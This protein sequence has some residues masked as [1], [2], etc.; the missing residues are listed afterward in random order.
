MN[1]RIKVGID[2]KA[3]PELVCYDQS[4][5]E[6]P[7]RSALENAP[8]NFTTNGQHYHRVF[9]ALPATASVRARIR[10]AG[11]GAIELADLEFQPVQVDSYQTGMLVDPTYASLRKGVVLESNFGIA[12]RERISRED[13]DGDGKWALVTVDLD[14]LTEPAKRG[15]DWR[16]RFEQN[17]NAIYWSDGA[18]LKSDTVREDVRP[19][20]DRALHYRGRVH[21]GPYRVRV[22]D[23]GRSVAVSIDGTSWK[24]YEG[25]SEIDLGTRDLGDGV[26]EFWLDACYRDPVSAGPAYF[27]YVRLSPT[28]DERAVE[29]LWQRAAQTPR[30]PDRGSVEERRVDITV[31]ASRF[32]GAESWPVRCGLPI[33]RGELAKPGQVAIETTEGQRH[34]LPG[35]YARH[36]ARWQREMAHAR[37]PASLGP[38]GR[39]PISRGLW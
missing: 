39:W 22:S 37:L 12:N 11:R 34:R 2:T 29:A 38:G 10:G 23:P 7:G 26:V 6:I 33:P 5:A 15:E 1:V 25:G 32:A 17:A 35:T 9:A 13:R 14:R 30:E 21:P 16:A 27:D 28:N 20:R 36:V 4:G 18:V 8:G 19:D 24:R 31:G 3:L